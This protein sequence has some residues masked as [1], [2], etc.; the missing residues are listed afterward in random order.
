M[1][2][3]ISFQ[4][5]RDF[6]GG[7]NLARSRMQLA[8]NESPDL[9]NVD[10]DARGGFRRRRGT[11]VYGDIDSFPAAGGSSLHD[12]A[13]SD[14]THKLFVGTD[15]D[16]FAWSGTAWDASPTI[17]FSGSPGPFQT[18][19]FKDRMYVYGRQHPQVRRWDGS[20]DTQLS[21]PAP[22]SWNDDLDSPTIAPSNGKMPK[23]TVAA[24]YQGSL[25]V[26]NTVENGT[27]YPCRVRWSHPL[28]PED[29]RAI[30]F[31][32]IEPEDGDEITA[33]VPMGDRLLVFKH[34]SVHAIYGSPPEG[35]ATAPASREFG[36]PHAQAVVGTDVGAMFWDER[37]G[38]MLIE[39]SGKAE[40]IGERIF[41]AIED[42]RIVE[43]VDVYVG[44]IK[45]R[46]WVSVQFEDTDFNAVFVYDPFCGKNGAWTKYAHS[47]GAMLEWVTSSGGVPI[48]LACSKAVDA[49]LE[50]E[51]FDLW[52]D[53][54]TESTD[55]GDVNA[56]TAESYYTTRWWDLGEHVVKKRWK[57]PECV[58]LGGQECTIVVEIF[59]D[60]DA[61]EFDRTFSLITVADETA[62]VWDTSE[63]DEAVWG[64]RDDVR[65][66]VK[67]GGPL[68]IARSVALKFN[69]PATTVPWQI[70]ALTMKWLPKRVRS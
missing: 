8:D 20:T 51:V 64:G 2:R 70:D 68:G 19:T 11:R 62:G 44:W 6:T 48:P 45:R 18:V 30:D 49:A 16:L 17:N 4:T 63:W 34:R 23:A 54:L 67:R 26:A 33:L 13:K 36:A 10:V 35:L 28:F 5:Q 38:P 52:G 21:E 12:F 1:A 59:R 22:S 25:F 42:N 56:A 15:S 31:I 14:G 55:S 9:L 57:R 24:A 32:D 50:L 41:P 37:I 3:Q 47:L 40:W 66:V 53:Y 27:S 58:L 65:G 60:Y 7:L 29:W 69:G 46:L 43:M 39:A 61:S